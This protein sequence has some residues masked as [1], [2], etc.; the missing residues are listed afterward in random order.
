LASNLFAGRYWAPCGILEPDKPREVREFIS[1]TLNSNSRV[2]P[3]F[4]VFAI[5][6]T[7]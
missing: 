4:M 3:S 1:V 6:G 5:S 2:S 7:P